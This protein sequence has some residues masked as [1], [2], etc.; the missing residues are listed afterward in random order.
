MKCWLTPISIHMHQT[1]IYMTYEAK[2]PLYKYNYLALLP[3]IG[4]LTALYSRALSV[5][6]IT[7]FLVNRVFVSFCVRLTNHSL[8]FSIHIVN[9]YCCVYLYTYTVI[10]Y[11]RNNI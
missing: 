10:R 7:Y 11:L 4:R 2:K 9:T 6:T 3:Y 8:A 5:L 1:H